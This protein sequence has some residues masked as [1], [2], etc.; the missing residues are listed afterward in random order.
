M[1][2]AVGTTRATELFMSGKR[3]SGQQA[4]DWGLFTEAVPPE[5]LEERL[6]K[7]ITKYANGPT[8]AYG[9]IKTLINRCAYSD[10]STGT[11]S[12][13]ELQGECEQTEDFREAVFAFFDKRRPE[14][15]G[16]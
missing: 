9:N 14:F 12:E 10:W 1:T 11:Y 2:K 16:K 6:Q 15:K 13:V 8:V 5:Q 4:A 7:Y 3:F